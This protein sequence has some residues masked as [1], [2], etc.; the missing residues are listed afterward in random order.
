MF[1]LALYAQ[2]RSETKMQTKLKHDVSDVY[3]TQEIA[4]K[5]LYD[6]VEK[7]EKQQEEYKK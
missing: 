7:L 4:L 6:R 2:F 5:E 3:H 1:L